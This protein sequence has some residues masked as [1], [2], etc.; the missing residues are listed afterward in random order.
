MTASQNPTARRSF[1]SVII[2]LGSALSI[3]ACSSSALGSGPGSATATAGNMQGF[4]PGTA[5]TVAAAAT[6]FNARMDDVL[7]TASADVAASALSSVQ[8]EFDGGTVID[9]R[10]VL[11]TVD[12]VPTLTNR[13]AIA[14]VVTNV[15]RAQDVG[16]PGASIGPLYNK[17]V[18]SL[19]DAVSG[20]FIITFRVLEP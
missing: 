7:G 8:K 1:A 11:L 6:A 4:P 20:D 19:Y 9:Q 3:A 10:H 17:C 14:F 2:A 18:V 13:N 15:P 12:G 5:C 16:P